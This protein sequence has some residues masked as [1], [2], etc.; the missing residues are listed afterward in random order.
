MSLGGSRPYLLTISSSLPHFYFLLRQDLAVGPRFSLNSLVSCRSLLHAGITGSG[1]H[2]WLYHEGINM[3][4][5]LQS[6]NR[7]GAPLC[8]GTWSQVEPESG[9]SPVFPGGTLETGSF[10]AVLE[11]P[12]SLAGRV[13][14]SVAE[15]VNKA[16]FNVRCFDNLLGSLVPSVCCPAAIR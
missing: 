15:P 11:G 14:L 7:S 10:P 4:K 8:L 9:I 16:D 5:S 13:W 2:T 12:T 6:G 1:R 3:S